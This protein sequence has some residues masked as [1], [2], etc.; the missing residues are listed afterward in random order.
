MFLYIQQLLIK[1]PTMLNTQ[2]RAT[3]QKIRS[4]ESG[5]YQFPQ[6]DADQWKATANEAKSSADMNRFQRQCEAVEDWNQ[7]ENDQPTDRAWQN[8]AVEDVIVFKYPEIA[9]RQCGK[10]QHLQ[11][12]RFR[13]TNLRLQS[14]LWFQ[15]M[16]RWILWNAWQVF[17]AIECAKHVA[18]STWQVKE[19]NFY[20]EIMSPSCCH[21]TNLP[22]W[23]RWESNSSNGIKSPTYY[24]YTTFPIGH[25]KNRTCTFRFTICWTATIRHSPFAPAR[26]ERTITNS[27][28]VVL[29]TTPQRMPPKERIEL[30]VLRLTAVCSAIKLLRLQKMDQPRIKLGPLECK[31][32]MLSL[33]PLILRTLTA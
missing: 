10:N 11:I 15:I 6:T 32:N 26:F 14:N 1:R 3:K 25:D 9:S 31:S 21:Y 13:A 4:H 22:N 27:K 16:N 12:E 5:K 17:S 28:S 29:P 2:H 23:E 33:T 20:L 8:W 18:L 19:S 7:A 30:Y 24:H